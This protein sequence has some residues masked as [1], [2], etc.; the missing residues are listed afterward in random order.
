MAAQISGLFHYPIKGLSAQALDHVTLQQGQGFPMDRMLGFGRH[1]SGFDP[2]N[3][4]PLPKGR[5]VVLARDAAL[6]TLDTQYDAATHTLRVTHRSESTAYDLADPMAVDVLVR[7]LA[8]HVGISSAALPRLHAA[9]PH[10]FTDVSVVSP[11]MMNAV[12]LLNAESVAAFSKDLGQD[13][14]PAR[15]RANLVFEGLPAFA[16]FD[17]I[18][19]RV[20]VGGVAFDVVQRTQRCPATEVN[21]DTGLRDIDVPK[22]LQRL[23][24][25]RDMGVYAHVVQ[26]GEIRLGDALKL[27]ETQAAEAP[28]A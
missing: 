3:P 21:L 6:A 13:I 14:S 9:A 20:A 5:F 15:F 24:G 11:Q 25:H 4:R 23:Y 18:G 28:S 26:G 19:K 7:F 2:E 10:R 8:E 16:E 1:N 17:W 27:G 12:S 22:A